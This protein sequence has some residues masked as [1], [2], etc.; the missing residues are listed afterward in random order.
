MSGILSLKLE[1]KKRVAYI[2]SLVKST[3]AEITT[4]VPINTS[5]VNPALIKKA[6]R[7]A[8]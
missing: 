6:V 3:K 2:D 5:F 7:K 4:A 8:P 1:S